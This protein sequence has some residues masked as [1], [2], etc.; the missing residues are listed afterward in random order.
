[1]K[2]IKRKCEIEARHFVRYTTGCYQDKICS[3]ITEALLKRDEKI[4]WLRSEIFHIKQAPCRCEEFQEKL[5]VASSKIERLENEL[6]KS[7]R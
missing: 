6:G 3:E 2:E 1:M 7:K 5:K 4:E